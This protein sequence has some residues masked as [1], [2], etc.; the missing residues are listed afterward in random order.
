MPM[1][2]WTRVDAGIYHHFHNAWLHAL[3]HIL[4]NGV[5]PSGYYALADQVVY[6]LGPD[7]LA[8]RPPDPAA[9]KGPAGGVALASSPPAVAT[10]SRATIQPV[11]HAYNRLAVRHLSGHRVIAVIELVSPGNKS[12]RKRLTQFVDKAVWLMDQGVHFLLVDPLPPGKRDPSGMH[13]AVWKALTRESFVP[14]PDRPLTAAAYAA[15]DDVTAFVNPFAVGM[16]VPTMPL[17]LT[18]DE[19]VNVPLDETYQAAFA[20]VPA[21]WRTVLDA[22]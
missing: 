18:P 12:S 9:P 10:T 8:L 3:G 19:Y 4:N 2:D 21:L 6:P 7:V 13:A 20:D 1:H 14:P 16:P 11:R 22:P 5:L 17:F 15:E